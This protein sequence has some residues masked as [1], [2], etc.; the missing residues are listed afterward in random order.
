MTISLRKVAEHAT[1]DGIVLF[2]QK[3]DVVAT[4]QEPLE[5][6]LSIFVASL[7]YVVIDQPEA[8]G[9]EGALARRQTVR[10]I[11]RLIS[12]DEFT[13]DQQLLFDGANGSL[14]TRIARGKKPN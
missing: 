6:T 1:R 14:H 11:L 7:Q 8:A 10:R 3:P 2:R 5:H 9:E 13:I 12:Q 4:G